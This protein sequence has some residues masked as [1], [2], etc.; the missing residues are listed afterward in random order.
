M[1]TALLSFSEVGKSYLAGSREM[2]VLD[3]E[4]FEIGP[5]ERVGVYG[6]PRSG[7]SSLLRLAAGIES[8]DTGVVSFEGR[9]IAQM[10]SSERPRLLRGP[11]GFMAPGDWH[12][13]P[14]ERVID[15]LVLSLGSDG[16][17]VRE[18]RRRALRSLDRVGLSATCGEEYAGS[19]PVAERMRVML[20]RAL[21]REPQLLLVDEP[22]SIPSLSDREALCEL[23]RTVTSEQ[24]MALLI[25]SQELAALREVDIA[26]SIGGGKLTSTDRLATVLRFPSTRR[27][28]AESSG[29]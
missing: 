15:H 11:I 1:M 6:S 13:N 17:T 24:R 9:N 2:V 20:A 7:K 4:S 10:S 27:I 29:S 19:L 22:A 8:P 18:A 28:A 3:R 16:L 21:A 14:R 25:A 26:M 5:H 12:P 23:L